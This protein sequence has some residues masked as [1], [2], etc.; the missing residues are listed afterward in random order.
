MD[1]PFTLDHP[2]RLSER[3][4][5]DELVECGAHKVCRLLQCVVHI[6]RYA[7]GD[8]PSVGG[9]SGHGVGQQVRWQL[10]YILRL[11]CHFVTTWYFVAGKTE[12]LM[13]PDVA[14]PSPTL[15]LRFP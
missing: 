7:G 8:A 14:L 3:G 9:R 2:L 10:E 6:L 5:N 15:K 4:L 12:S 13:E 11:R 1:H